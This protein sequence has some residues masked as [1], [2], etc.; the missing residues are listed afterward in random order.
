[1]FLGSA[2]N[3]DIITPDAAILIERA[4]AGLNT[5]DGTNGTTLENFSVVLSL[6]GG[7]NS[8]FPIFGLPAVQAVIP[9]GNGSGGNAALALVVT[10]NLLLNS[11]DLSTGFGVNAAGKSGTPFG[12]MRDE[13][14]TGIYPL[15]INFLFS[16]RSVGGSN[17]FITNVMF[18]YRLIHGLSEA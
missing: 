15:Q 11:Y 10:P 1:M 6:G 3:P 5:N 17:V 8:P 9:T 13:N 2:A 12:P 18:W 7:I 16:F 14:S 4:S